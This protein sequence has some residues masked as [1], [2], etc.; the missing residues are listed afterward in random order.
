MNLSQLPIKLLQGH[1][2]FLI[3]HNFCQQLL[4]F[5][6]QILILG[7]YVLPACALCITQILSHLQWISHQ[8]HGNVIVSMGRQGGGGHFSKGWGSHIW[9]TQW[10][11]MS[12]LPHSCKHFKD[13][14]YGSCFGICMVTTAAMTQHYSSRR[15]DW[16][17]VVEQGR[18]LSNY[19]SGT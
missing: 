1:G 5:V 9:I 11:W 4:R 17:V 8:G 12:G 10:Q 18:S 3:T 7:K 16:D 14:H 6:V 19:F 13:P 2:R 15:A